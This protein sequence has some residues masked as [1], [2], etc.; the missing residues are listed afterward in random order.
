VNILDEMLIDQNQIFMGIFSCS[1]E[2][3]EIPFGIAEMPLL[4]F[5]RTADFF[6]LR[7][8]SFVNVVPYLLL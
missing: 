5:K 6:L 7:V 2:L 1:F 4:Y 3:S 8:N